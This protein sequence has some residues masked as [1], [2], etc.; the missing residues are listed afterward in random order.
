MNNMGTAQELAARVLEGTD[1]TVSDDSEV[2]VQTIEEP[3]V[4]AKLTDALT[5]FKITNEGDKGGISSIGN[6]EIP[7]GSTI[8]AFYSC[9]KNKPHRFQF[10]YV[11]ELDEITTDSR[12]VIDLK[13]IQYYVDTTER[14]KTEGVQDDLYRY[15]EE[16]K[17]FFLPEGWKLITE[18]VPNG[19]STISSKYRGLRYGFS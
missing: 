8:L 10:I 4:Y 15:G 1:W 14:E 6:H 16:Q 3:L 11:P 18:D 17:G 9:T 2:I 12:G 5:C 13:N 19:D 7:A